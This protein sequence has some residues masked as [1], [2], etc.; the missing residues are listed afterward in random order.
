MAYESSIPANN[1]PSRWA[2]LRALWIA[3][4]WRIRV[5]F[6]ALAC[7]LNRHN[8]EDC[9]ALDKDGKPHLDESGK[10]KPSMYQR[11]KRPTCRVFS[12]APTLLEVQN[13]LESDDFMV[14]ARKGCP[15]CHGRGYSRKMLLPGPA[16]AKVPCD[17]VRVQPRYVERVTETEVKRAT[18][19]KATA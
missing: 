8:W 4:T 6:G 19:V 1:K 9:P 16:K 18:N 11:C 12:A 15:K 14:L 7:M 3:K 5:L 2:P 13:W 10:T 17:C